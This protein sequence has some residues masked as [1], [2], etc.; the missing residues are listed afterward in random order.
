MCVLFNFA[1]YLLLPNGLFTILNSLSVPFF[2]IPALM[3]LGQ[4]AFRLIR[5][6]IDFFISFQFFI[7]YINSL[8]LFV[9][10]FRAILGKQLFV[11]FFPFVK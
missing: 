5:R 4:F 7:L 10:K 1:V 6:L 8:C 2:I 11:V 3:S 9:Y